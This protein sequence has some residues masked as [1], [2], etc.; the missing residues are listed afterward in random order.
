MNNTDP[1]AF[2]R[3]FDFF[4]VPPGRPAVPS[5]LPDPGRQIDPGRIGQ[6]PSQ[7]FGFMGPQNLGPIDPFA[8]RFGV[9]TAPQDVLGPN[10]FALDR[11]ARDFAIGLQ[12]SPAVDV[13]GPF[14]RSD[15]NSFF[16]G[17]VSDRGFVDPFESR[18]GFPT[19]VNNPDFPIGRVDSIND[20]FFSP[21]NP[22]DFSRGIGLDPNAPFAPDPFASRFGFPVDVSIPTPTPNPLDPFDR[23]ISI[24]MPAPNPLAPDERTNPLAITVTPFDRGPVPGVPSLPFAPDPSRAPSI[25][26][27]PAFP[28][29][30]VPAVP[31][32]PFGR[33]TDPM[34]GAGF[35]PQPFDP[36]ARDPLPPGFG[37]TVPPTIP[38]NFPDLGSGQGMLPGFPSQP[39]YQPSQPPPGFDPNAFVQ[40]QD[41][42][43]TIDPNL[44]MLLQA[45]QMYGR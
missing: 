44:L 20:P 21:F 10:P 17:P 30:G 38:A 29:P 25:P 3:G 16:T 2:E 35:F 22:A 40:E 24:P 18:F 41:R 7:V 45:Q 37:P 26:G 1:N 9:F 5:L 28:D 43:G 11:D 32:D 6:N 23:G 15:P 8:D 36:Y 19:P 42:G 34:M 39:V 31:F 4:D 13:S 27:F 14:G 33:P 12:Q